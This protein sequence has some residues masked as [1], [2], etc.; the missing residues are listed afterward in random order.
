MSQIIYP[1]YVVVD[2]EKILTYE[3]LRAC[4]F[5]GPTAE[6]EYLSGMH[7]INGLFQAKATPDQR[8]LMDN[9]GY[10]LAP[11]ITPFFPDRRLAME[12]EADMEVCID[13]DDG[14]VIYFEEHQGLTHVA[15]DHEGVGEVIS[16]KGKFSIS[17][18]KNPLPAPTYDILEAIGWNSPVPKMPTPDEV[19]AQLG[20]QKSLE[21][22][23]AEAFATP[24]P[25][26][27]KEQPTFT[28]PKFFTQPEPQKTPPKASEPE[29]AA[30]ARQSSDELLNSMFGILLK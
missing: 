21:E 24:K 12:P 13:E 18:Y 10:S 2:G 7:G 23:F 9:F 3:E 1:S 16:L 20:S 6:A 27:K 15:L 30:P 11:V 8:N 5:I 17:M 28:P 25:A 26:P 22:Q 14:E 4:G 19:L 29:K